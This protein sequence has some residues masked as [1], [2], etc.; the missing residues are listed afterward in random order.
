MPRIEVLG[1]RNSLNVQK[2]MWTLGE[3]SLD[4]VRQDVGGSFGYPDSYK[5]INPNPLVPALVDGEV[6][7]WESNACVRYLA[8][9]YGRGSL[10]PDEPATLAEA[11]QWMDWQ[12]TRLGAAF[13]PAFMNMVRL[14]PERA[15]QAV[16]KSGLA[17]T[18]DLYGLLDRHLSARPYLAGDQ[19]TM[20]DIPLGPMTY[21]YLSMDID[22]PD[23]PH[24][25]AWYTRLTQ[26]DAFAY[27]AMIPCG[28]N[29]AEWQENEDANAGIQ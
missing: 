23:I 7:L 5:S 25:Q 12:T 8:R 17:A 24:V 13:L 26:R 16:I 29:P 28:R 9:S 18:A 1:R 11:D 6:T 14:S 19:F 22:R 3:L 4:Y 10:W 15:N 20:G 27:H 21:R 2:V